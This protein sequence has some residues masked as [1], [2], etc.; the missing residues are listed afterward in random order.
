VSY[1][2]PKTKDYGVNLC[3]NCLDKQ[4]EIES[5]K[6]ENLRLKQKLSQNQRK[7]KAG[8]FGSS[9]SSAKLPVKV[10]SL[11]EKPAKQGGSQTLAG[12]LS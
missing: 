9:T 8:F 7:I 1:Q 3:E 10:N 6:E 4:R 11:S 2:E 5:L 12:F